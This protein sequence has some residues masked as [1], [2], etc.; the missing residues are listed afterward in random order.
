MNKRII[1]TLIIF[2]ITAIIAFII[3]KST[4]YFNQ[5][6]GNN[7]QIPINVNNYGVKYNGWLKCNGTTL[8]NERG[9]I[10]QLRG[11]SSH[12]IE[13]FYDLITN[14]NLE[15]LKD[16]WNTNVFRIAMYTD[17]NMDGYIFFPENNKKIVYDVI[18]RLVNLDMYVI[19]DWHILNDKT[20]Q[21][22]KDEAKAFFEEVSRKYSNVPNVI[23]EICNEPNGN[24]VTWEKDVKPYAEEVIQIIRKNSP[25]SLIIVGTPEW[26][27]YIDKAAENPLNYDNIAYSCHFYSGSHGEELRNK[28]EYCLQK[29][30][31][32]FVSECGVTNANGNGEIYLKEF[33]EWIEYL[34]SKGI[35][36]IYWSFSNKDESSAILLPGRKSLKNGNLTK[37]GEYIRNCIKLPIN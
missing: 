4:N 25:K 6:N 33:S 8:E 22:H 15:T 37:S 7:R 31:L 19:I 26:C 18:D 13:W 27:T 1:I 29:N 11:V 28:I 9:Q 16:E 2:I 17:V 12:G 3:F 35:S 24:K 23:Y 32:V 20:P 10:I 36:W 21:T 34:N 14:E 30:I 5:N